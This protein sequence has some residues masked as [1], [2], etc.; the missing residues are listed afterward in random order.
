M[1]LLAVNLTNKN[2]LCTFLRFK[3][4]YLIHIVSLSH[5]H[6]GSKGADLIL[7]CDV[8]R[9]LATDWPESNAT[10]QVMMSDLS[11]GSTH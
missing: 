2:I 1:V 3:I 11:S 8:N 4:R 10:G 7:L 6:Q 9:L 5:L